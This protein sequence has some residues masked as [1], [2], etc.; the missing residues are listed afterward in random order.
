M[1]LDLAT[2]VHVLGDV[3]RHQRGASVPETLGW[4][5]EVEAPGDAAACVDGPVGAGLLPPFEAF[6]TWVDAGATPDGAAPARREP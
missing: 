5:P 3:W 4:S 2:F 1:S 6:P